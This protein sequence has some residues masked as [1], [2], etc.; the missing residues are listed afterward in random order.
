[1]SLTALERPRVAR[2]VPKRSSEFDS[3]SMPTKKITP[4]L[5]PPITESM[6]TPLDIVKVEQMIKSEHAERLAF[7]EDPIKIL[8]HRSG[9]KFSPNCTDLIAVNG[10]KAEML[11]KNGWVQIGWLPRGQSFYTKRKYV[12]QIAHAFV[13]HVS[14]RVVENKNEDPMNFIDPVVSAVFAFSILEDK[15][16]KAAVWLEQLMQQHG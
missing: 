15:S 14:T 3:R 2:R 11:F 7:G 12:E 10:V 9:E 16:P 4:I 8:I 13:K 5:Q 6:E 1:M